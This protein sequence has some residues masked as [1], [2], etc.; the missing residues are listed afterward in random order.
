MR[1]VTIA[2]VLVAL[3]AVAVQADNLA[4]DAT[5][6]A[7]SEISSSLGPD[8]INDGIVEGDPWHS[9]VWA[10]ANSAGPHWVQLSWAST[11][12]FNEV[13]VYGIG[14]VADYEDMDPYNFQ[15]QISDDGQAW[16]TIDDVT[17][18]TLNAYTYSSPSLINT[19]YLRVYITTPNDPAGAS[20]DNIARLAEVEVTVPEPAT[21]GMLAIGA[22][23]G[24]L[25][26]RS[27]K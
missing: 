3:L 18:N 25:R 11:V 16:A 19:Q 15:I 21:I 13:K 17:A 12:A 14:H 7:S 8:K 24:V 27:Q 20:S 26:R 6:D 5:A 1:R 2:L 9:T 10:S 23:A 4:L 22:F